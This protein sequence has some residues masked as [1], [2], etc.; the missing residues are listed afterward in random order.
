MSTSEQLE[1]VNR[2]T[3]TQKNNQVQKQN[4]TK[5]KQNKTKQ[6]KTK[7]NKTKTN[8]HGKELLQ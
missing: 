5:Q 3:K 1:N 2:E 6:N 8:Y 7:Q 4:K